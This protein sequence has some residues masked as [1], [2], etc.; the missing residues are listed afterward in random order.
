MHKVERGYV[1]IPLETVSDKDVA[2]EPPWMGSRRVSE[3][4]TK[5]RRG[6]EKVRLETSRE[7]GLGHG[8][9]LKE[10]PTPAQELLPQF[11]EFVN[12]RFDLLRGVRCTYAAAQ[13]AGTTGCCRG[14]HHVDVNTGFQQLIPF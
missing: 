10:S 13:E 9:K 6:S 3:G 7:A 2:T 8:T 11:H 5:C 12:N 1:V 4:I 14:Q